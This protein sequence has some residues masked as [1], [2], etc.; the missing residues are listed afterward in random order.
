M[1]SVSLTCK[2]FAS[3]AFAS[4]LNL[5]TLFIQPLNCGRGG[6]SASTSGRN[7]VSVLSW[8]GATRKL[9]PGS[10]HGRICLSI[11]R[12]NPVRSMPPTLSEKSTKMTTAVP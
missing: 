5:I 1:R 7:W 11:S 2:I 8:M 4:R 6:S 3:V 9:S 10:S 12:R